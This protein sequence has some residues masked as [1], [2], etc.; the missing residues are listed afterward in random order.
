MCKEL[1]EGSSFKQKLH[2]HYPIAMTRKID[3]SY[4]KSGTVQWINL[5]KAYSKTCVSSNEW[6]LFGMLNMVPNA[7]PKRT[8]PK[9]FLDL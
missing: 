8:H 9:S 6:I 1:K 3:E 7:F 2:M 5:L 4:A